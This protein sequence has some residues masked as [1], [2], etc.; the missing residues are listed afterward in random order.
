MRWKRRLQPVYITAVMVVAVTAE[1]SCEREDDHCIGPESWLQ[2]L[3]RSGGSDPIIYPLKIESGDLD[4]VTIRGIP[5]D[6][7][8]T[9]RTSG[10]RPDQDLP[11]EHHRRRFTGVLP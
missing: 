5:H 9:K 1:Y 4:Q 6:D 3:S 2:N 11:T 8:H 7:V 10:P